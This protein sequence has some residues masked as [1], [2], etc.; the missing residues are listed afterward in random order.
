MKHLTK[1]EFE[2]QLTEKIATL[3]LANPDWKEHQLRME[4]IKEVSEAIMKEI[5]KDSEARVKTMEEVKAD[6]EAGKDSATKHQPFEER[7]KLIM[8]KRDGLCKE[9]P[10][11][12]ELKLR[13]EAIKQCVH[14]KLID[15]F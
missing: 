11:W 12:P 14:E 1:E 4:A 5:E 7:G 15:K 10:E 6:A 2:K 3:K 9:H 8:A 13:V